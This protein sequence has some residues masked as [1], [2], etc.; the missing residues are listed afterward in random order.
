MMDFF[1]HSPCD[2]FSHKTDVVVIG[3]GILGSAITKTMN[4]MGVEVLLLDN[5]DDMCG[6]RPSGGSIKFSPLVGIPKDLER[7]VTRR[8][9]ELFGLTEE[10]FQIRPS[11]KLLK[12]QVYQINMDNVLQTP[13]TYGHVF[14][15]E[16][17]D[18]EVFYVDGEKS[19]RR[20]KTKLIVVAAGAGISKLLPR[21][22]GKLYGR[23]G[24]SFLFPGQIDQA[25]VSLWAPHKQVTV[26]NFQYKGE[27]VIWGC[28]GI[29]LKESSWKEHTTSTSLKR[30]KQTAGIV[31]EPL[32][33]RHGIRIYHKDDEKPCFW[34]PVAEGIWVAAGAGKFG[35]I[36][37]GWI[38]HRLKKDFRR[39]V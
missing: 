25:F 34:K 4:S 20:V 9:D 8:L 30:I 24:V 36:C 33:I 27:T 2:S 16:L 6:T 32:E 21:F 13:R 3:A 12:A 22:E 11:M 28:D 29:K 26:H 23:K 19:F 31:E 35:G 10:T 7:A 1:F 39:L 14:N 15:L 18:K 37:A 38:A 17:K 5:N